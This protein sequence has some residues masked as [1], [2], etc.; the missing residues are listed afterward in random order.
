[1]DIYIYSDESGVFDKQHNDFFVFAGV[2]L[3]GKEEK[4]KWTR[5][6]SHKEK[7]LRSAKGVSCELKANFLSNKE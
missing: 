5:M 2:I 1:M 3:L 7:Q 6:Y 4:D